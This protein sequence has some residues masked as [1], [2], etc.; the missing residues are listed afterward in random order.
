MVLTIL[1]TLLP[2]LCFG[3]VALLNCRKETGSSFSKDYT[4]VLKGLCSI[5]VV[6]VH[7][8]AKFGN[9]IQDS[10]GSFAYVAV[11]LFFMISSY[12]MMVSVERKR[13]YL[14]S[15]WRNR[16]ASLLI[17]CFLINI[18]Q[19]LVGALCGNVNY[20][21]LYQLNNYV[22]VLLQFCLLF[23]IVQ[24][25]KE[26]WFRDNYRL[27]DNLMILGVFISS[28]ILYFFVYN[29]QTCSGSWCFERMGLVW[30]II[31]YRYESSILVWINS[32]RWKKVLIFLLLSGT[33]GVM[34]LKFKEV[35]FVGE[36][37]L[38]IILGLTII[39]FLF[40]ISFGY[41]FNNV[42]NNWLGGISFETYLIHAFIMS[43]IA[44]IVPD[45]SSGLFILGTFVLTLLS[46]WFVHVMSNLIVSSLRK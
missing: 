9:V 44:Q 40:L 1:L 6:Y 2:I 24:K 34:Y 4:T 13:D 15:F 38:K 12:G 41:R 27:A 35:Y 32:A 10:I 37:M 43:V 18:C 16:L 22:W 28:I 46:A 21:V 26:K 17:P 42:I 5:V 36:Y 29:P 11:T 3:G 45:L 31:F 8:P 20:T 25:C 7:F 23:Y 33:L 30:G 39:T 19:L 14:T